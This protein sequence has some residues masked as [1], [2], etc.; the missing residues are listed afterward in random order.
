MQYG[1]NQH[2]QAVFQSLL[3]CAIKKKKK[4]N[5]IVFMYSSL[6]QTV[7][8]VRMVLLSDSLLIHKPSYDL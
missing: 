4:A 7:A 5:I 1:H 2:V 8:K 3:R 6:L